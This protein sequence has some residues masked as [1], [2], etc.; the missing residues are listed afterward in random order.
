MVEAL[1]SVDSIN[2]LELPRAL[3]QTL[4]E[5]S[6]KPQPMSKIVEKDFKGLYTYLSAFLWLSLHGSEN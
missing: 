5:T 6:E 4:P 2:T 3:A 1:D